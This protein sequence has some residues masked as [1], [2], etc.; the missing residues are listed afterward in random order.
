MGFSMKMKILPISE[1]IVFIALI[2]VVVCGFLENIAADIP[3]ALEFTTAIVFLLLL[4]ALFAVLQDINNRLLPYQALGIGAIAFTANHLFTEVSGSYIADFPVQYFIVVIA[5]ALIGINRAW[6]LPLM[7]FVFGEFFQ[8][9]VSRALNGASVD[10][11]SIVTQYYEKN[12]ISV[13]YLFI[14]GVF[15]SIISS[16]FLR[17]A[18]VEKNKTSGKRSETQD[19]PPPRT[20]TSQ[21]TKTQVL[22]AG[23]LQTE[24]KTSIGAV[25]DLLASV[26]YFMKRNF[27]A[28]SALGFT[29][30]TPTQSF[31]LN[32]F[33]SKSI[34]INNGISIAAGNGIIGQLADK[35]IFM[36]GDLSFYNSGIDYYNSP[37]EINSILA[38]P[39]VSEQNELLGALVLDSV[40]KNAFR[41][42][43]KDILKRFSSLAA[44]LI[45]NARMRI[46]QEQAAR[47]FQLF[48]EASHQL[49]TALNLNDVFDVMLQTGPSVA[50]C[51]RQ[52]AIL[53][54]DETRSGRIIKI[55]GTSPDIPEGS[56]FPINSGIYSYAFKKRIPVNIP[57][58]ELYKT[59][60]YRFVPNELQTLVIR[61]LLI[62]PI[63]DDEGRCKGLYSIESDRPNMYMGETEQTFKTLIE[64]ASVA[65]TRALLYQR[66]EKLA[67]TDGLTELNNHRHFQ[68]LLSKE[69]ER[70]RRYGSSV[71]LLLMDID[72]FKSFNDTYGH[73]VGDLVLKEISQCI[74]RSLRTNDIP[75]RY[76]GEEFTVIIPESNEQG[77]LII[78][79]RIRSAIENHIIISNDRQLHVTVSIGVAAYPSLATNQPQLID[80]AD[81]ALYN[82]KEHGRNRVT[83]F[84]PGM[85]SGKKK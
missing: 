56:G 53:F 58:Y 55:S 24:H 59:K 79:E 67:T 41:D 22:T 12:I 37:Q 26:V 33:H 20:D 32:S 63:L 7:V 8:P 30:D 70:T 69:I 62:F 46:F 36:S 29:F 13:F 60:H 42:Q 68:E 19:T 39:V 45:T 18:F 5:T 85:S 38:V 27:K 66:M 76:G 2:T 65:F 47:T 80:S 14:S 9:I 64:N 31:I 61:S 82:S 40:D 57:D 10:I 84:A 15:P 48:Y 1:S 44:A 50:H 34:N 21:L 72:H 16:H 71:A 77:A 49:T 52:M 74:K 75:A 73:P 17:I 25:D 43:D 11:A 4:F 54:D 81:K 78:A 23:E 51:T 6:M 28:Y 35:K 3:F 83:I